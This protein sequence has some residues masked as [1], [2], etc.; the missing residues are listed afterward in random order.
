MRPRSETREALARAADY[1]IRR[2]VEAQE[3]TYAALA[4][5]RADASSRSILGNNRDGH[6]TAGVPGSDRAHPRLH[7]GHRSETARRRCRR[8]D[9]QP[10]TGPLWTDA[11]DRKSVV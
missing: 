5:G 3:R 11:G 9:E 4:G 10:W 2:A 6:H 1:D 7:R 8:T